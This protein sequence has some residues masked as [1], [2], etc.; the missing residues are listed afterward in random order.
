MAVLVGGP[1]AALPP[2][3]QSRRHVSV[4]FLPGVSASHAFRSLALVDARVV[5]LDKSGGLWAGLC[6]LVE[7]AVGLENTVAKAVS[8]WRWMQAVWGKVHLVVAGENIIGVGVHKINELH[9]TGLC[10]AC[11]STH[12]VLGA[13]SHPPRCADKKHTD[14]EH[15]EP[16]LCCVSEVCGHTACLPGERHVAS[17]H[18]KESP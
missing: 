12:R 15:Q 7:G 5:W 8:R 13:K 4:A 1:L 3:A 14:M 16:V 6:V 9:A 17:S 11:Q 18:P 10:F 2:S